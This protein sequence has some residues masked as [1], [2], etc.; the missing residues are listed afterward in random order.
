MDTPR[1]Q[2]FE[3]DGGIFPAGIGDFARIVYIY[4]LHSSDF[5]DILI[6]YDGPE[7]KERPMEMEMEEIYSTAAARGVSGRRSSRR[8][9]R[10]AATVCLGFFFSA[11]LSGVFLLYGPFPYFRELWVNTAME[12]MNHRWLAGLLF[13][14]KTV[15][16]IRAKSTP[17]MP[18]EATDPALVA[19]TTSQSASRVP[20]DN[21]TALPTSPADGEHIIHGVGFIR[22]RNN[23]L[24]GDSFNGWLVKVYDPARVTMGLSQNFGKSGEHIT[25][26]T[27]RTGSFLGI[28][29]GGFVDVDGHGNGGTPDKIL[30]YDHKQ[31]TGGGDSSVHS[32]IG[33]DD[34]SRLILGSYTQAALTAQHFRYAVEFSPFLIVNGKA[35]DVSGSGIQPRTAIGQK[36]DG[37]LLFVIIDGR[38]LTSPGATWE[39]VQ[40]IMQENGAVNAANLDGGSSTV[41]SYGGKLVNVPSSPYGERYLPDA[42]LVSYEK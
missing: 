28:N 27:T 41:L 42:F 22:L 37:T 13:D 36:A 24:K 10:T 4:R 19:G 38:S 34:S 23:S 39:D 2:E 5:A 11:V 29:A 1:I 32:I 7:R 40:K 3:P 16:A 33:L 25:D 26:M 6:P 9:G 20:A 12:T 14:S 17:K 15:A 18:G 30:I 31:L 21:A 8:R 35:T